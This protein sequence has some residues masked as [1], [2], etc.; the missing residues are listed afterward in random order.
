MAV[1]LS[2][3]LTQKYTKLTSIPKNSPQF[4][5]ARAQLPSHNP[6]L[7]KPLGY[8]RAGMLLPTL[9]V[10]KKHKAPYCA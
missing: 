4:V 1:P 10:L 7:P 8:T 5:R 2:I 3:D 9:S 6:F